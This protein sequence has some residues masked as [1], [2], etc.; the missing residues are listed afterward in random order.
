MAKST[1]FPLRSLRLERPQGVGVRKK[2]LKHCLSQSRRVHREIHDLLSAEI[3]E[4]IILPT[5][6]APDGAGVNTT[7]KGMRVCRYGSFSHTGKRKIPSLRPLRLERPQGVGVRKKPLKHCLSPAY[8]RARGEAF[9]FFPGGKRFL[10]YCHREELSSFTVIA[11][12]EATW[13]SIGYNLLNEI[14][15]L[16]SQ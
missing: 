9:F 12:S 6:S 5:L 4:T 14:A 1:R 16:R 10:L 11:R 8:A 2:P 3:R 13:R 7:R 15:T